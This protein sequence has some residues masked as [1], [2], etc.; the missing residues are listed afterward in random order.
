MIL[1]TF[2]GWKQ[3]P[4]ILEQDY[5]YRE[6][7]VVNDD[8]IDYYIPCDDGIGYHLFPSTPHS[9]QLDIIELRGEKLEDGF[10]ISEKYKGSHINSDGIEW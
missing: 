3:I 7:F 9:N 10:C 1:V 4:V 5:E 6:G 2:K 8:N